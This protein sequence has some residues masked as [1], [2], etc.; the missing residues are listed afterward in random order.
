MRHLL[1]HLNQL[2]DTYKSAVQFVFVYIE[3]AHAIDEWPNPSVNSCITQHR[4]MEDRFNAA[5]KLMTTFSFHSHC[6]VLLDNINN[7]YNR[8]LPS[9]PFR[10]YIAN[11]G[12]FELKTMPDGDKM[13]L[14]QLEEWLNINVNVM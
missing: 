11:K 7:D 14:L 9:W 1:P 5:Q 13:S 2:I 3:E 10:Y 12:V 8:L 4:S 6:K